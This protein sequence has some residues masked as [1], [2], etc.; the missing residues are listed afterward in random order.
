VNEHY[1]Q[2]Y[3]KETISAVLSLIQ[4]CIEQG[5]YTISMNNNRQE[6]KDF[7]AEYNLNT[8]R[9]KKL[10]LRI[11]TKDFCHSLKNTN[12]GYENEVLYV[13]VPQYKLFNI[14]GIE[15][16]VDVYTKFN[17][18]EYRNSRRTVVISFHERNKQISYCFR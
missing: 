6:N 7:V 17:L 16:V 1:N 15:K 5:N 14:D 18:I 11:K 8:K 13:F 12:P 2:N 9:Q 3:T 4:N 10:L